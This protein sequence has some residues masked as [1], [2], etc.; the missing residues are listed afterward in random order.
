MSHSN[1]SIFV[2]HSGCP[3]QCAFCN[4]KSITGSEAQIPKIEKVREICRQ[5]LAEVKNPKDTEIAFFGGS[6]TAIN[7]ADML[8]LLKTANEFIGKDK[9]CGI[10][11]ST[12]PDCIYPE[13]LDI[14]KQYNV[15]TIELGA[16]SMDDEVLTANERGHT[17]NDV[18]EASKLILEYGF[19]L[20]LQ[21][22]TGLYKSTPNSDI[23]T[24]KSIISLNPS[25]VRIYPTVIL[26]NTT[27]GE[28]FKKGIYESYSLEK[29]VE[30]CAE[31][32]EL[33]YEN[34]IPVIKLGLHA[35]ELV[36]AKMLG[37]VYHPAF[38]ELC[39]GLVF[40][41]R[42]NRELDLKGKKQ[43]DVLIPKGKLSQVIGQK[44]V[45]YEYFKN[46]GYS[47]RFIECDNLKGYQIKIE[48]EK[49]C[50]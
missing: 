48:E 34:N 8:N 49:S 31:L 16:Q 33:F 25:Q 28:Y 32:L 4:Q 9:F 40:R 36:E 11:I 24:A 26:D 20:G 37:G 10:R 2:P 23:M 50:I 18:A 47:L 6:F 42:I 17:A 15:K 5:A 44:K 3:H 27:L 46:R 14:L 30:L 41:N 39:E 7:R 22:M 19:D 1:I 21:M 35:S 45:N 12:R 43:A 29:T 13:I 38:R